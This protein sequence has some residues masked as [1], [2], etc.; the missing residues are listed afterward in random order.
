MLIK[1]LGDTWLIWM[2]SQFIY[3]MISGATLL[4]D[5]TFIAESKGIIFLGIHLF[6]IVSR[7]NKLQKYIMFE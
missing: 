7:N 4:L 5:V 2:S 6:L 1:A 3:H